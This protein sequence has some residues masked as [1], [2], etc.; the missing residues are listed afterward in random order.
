MEP[1]Y[2]TSRT[3]PLVVSLAKLADKKERDKTGLY[4]AEGFK[5]CKEACGRSRVRYAV[6]RHDREQQE[7]YTALAQR[8]GGE[9]IILSETAYDKITK[10]RSPDGILFV[11][12]AESM[13]IPEHMNGERICILDSIQDPGNVG[14]IIRTAAALGMDRVILHDCADIYNPKVIRATMGAFFKMSVSLCG[15]LQKTIALLQSEGRRVLAA[16]LS[17]QGI[18][19]GEAPL[20]PSDCPILGNEGHGIAEAVIDQCNA[21]IKIPMT[22]KTESLNAAAAAAVL[23]WEYS[24]LH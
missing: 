22:D 21:C 18:T 9:A 24:K 4:I 5:L 17:D 11:V 13:E 2:I 16:A 1:T 10:D 20:Y 19:L 8:S 15:N 3:N 23:L 7:Q 14:T 6:I 12:E